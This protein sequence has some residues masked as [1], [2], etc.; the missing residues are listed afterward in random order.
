MAHHSS[1]CFSVARLVLKSLLEA[2]RKKKHCMGGKLEKAFTSAWTGN[3]W[4]EDVEPLLDDRFIPGCS[5]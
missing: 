2:G 4:R 1:F 5:G 3:V